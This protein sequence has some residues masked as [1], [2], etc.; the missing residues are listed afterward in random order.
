MYIFKLYDI[1]STHIVMWLYHLFLTLKF[2]V[3]SRPWSNKSI[4][5]YIFLKTNA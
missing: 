1:S 4:L 5:T 3:S 2:P